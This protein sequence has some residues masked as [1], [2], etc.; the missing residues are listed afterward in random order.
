MGPSGA[1]SMQGPDSAM[2]SLMTTPWSAT[3]NARSTPS[4]KYL[5]SAFPLAN[6]PLLPPVL[7]DSAASSRCA[8]ACG[9]PC[10]G[11]AMLCNVAVLLGRPLSGKT[12]GFFIS[13]GFDAACF[14]RRDSGQSLPYVDFN[15][16]RGDFA[17]AAS[18]PAVLPQPFM[19]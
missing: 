9:H 11:S 5:T 1:C 10:L 8:C 17:G 13:L 18:S 12:T 3:Q 15:A 6:F 19:V 2:S 14:R 7:L 4:N 16:L